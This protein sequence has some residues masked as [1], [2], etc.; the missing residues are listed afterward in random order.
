[1]DFVTFMSS[2]LADSNSAYL[3]VYAIAV[4]LLTQL[5]KRL[6]LSKAKVDVL[7][8]F[9][10]SPILPFIFGLVFAVLDVYAVQRKAFA[11][12]TVVQT[13]FS[14]LAIGA[15]ASTGFQFV[16]RLSGQSLSALMKN[17]LFG[18]FYTQLLYFGNVRK[19]IVEK[20]L[21]LDDFIGK[22]KLLASD[23]EAIYKQE[24]SVDAKRCALAKL[25]SGIID[26]GSIETC[27]NA[28]NEALVR[29][30]ASN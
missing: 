7:H 15:L 18:V 2:V 23:A 24:G 3:L 4:C 8:K 26:E 10:W 13:L 14:T 17:D 21:T 22:V 11:F 27:V 19:Q 29:M 9:D 25:L 1:M 30:F 16:K 5:V 20:E 6:F 28:I 12:S